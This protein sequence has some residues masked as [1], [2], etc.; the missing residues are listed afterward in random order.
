[1]CICRP[2]RP[3]TLDGIQGSSCEQP[4]LDSISEDCV[5]INQ[6]PEVWAT[7]E[8]ST[9]SDVYSFGVLLWILM[10]G[11]EY[12]IPELLVRHQAR[13]S[14]STNR[15]GSLAPP[16]I[17]ASLQQSWGGPPPDKY[18]TLMKKCWAKSPDLRPNFGEIRSILAKIFEDLNRGQ[19]GVRTSRTSCTS[20]TSRTHDGRWPQHTGKEI[21]E[22]PWG[23]GKVAKRTW[24]IQIVHLRLVNLV[25]LHIYIWLLSGCL[26]IA[27]ES[28]HQLRVVKP[29]KKRGGLWVCVCCSL[30]NQ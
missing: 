29:P 12:R 9:K 6:P 16:E 28:I 7:G 18:V 14:S 30:L 27:G 4:K 20:L 5:N 10:T 1:M 23:H 11:K 21:Q 25:W 17:P 15:V 13:I 3:T 26:H 19:R 22:A 8:Y 24:Y 2:V